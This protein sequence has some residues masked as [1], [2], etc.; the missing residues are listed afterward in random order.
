MHPCFDLGNINMKNRSFPD[1]SRH[2][3]S[4][5]HLDLYGDLDSQK[6]E[7]HEYSCRAST[8]SYYALCHLIHRNDL[9]V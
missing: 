1:Q 4:V 5:N 7:D 6:Q 8:I 3:V 9:P 2:M